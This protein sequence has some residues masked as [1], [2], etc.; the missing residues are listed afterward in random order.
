MH[1]ST[2]K[3]AVMT[4]VRRSGQVVPTPVW[5]APL[6]D[7]TVGFTTN[8]TSGKVKRLRNN[9]NVTLQE[10][11]MRGKVIEGSPIV[12]GTAAVVHGADHDRVHAAIKAKYG[13]MVTLIG[14]GD[15]I[16][17]ILGKGQTPT[18]IIVTLAESA[19]AEPA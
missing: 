7:G 11:T 16:K 1:I 13:F 8:E 12:I 4:T 2:V 3:Y 17:K 19:L 9:P 5:V 15:R 18:A 10:C 6:A 14:I